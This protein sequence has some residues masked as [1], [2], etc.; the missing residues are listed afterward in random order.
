MAAVS[1]A[2]RDLT[3][4]RKFA[5][6]ARKYSEEIQRLPQILEIKDAAGIIHTDPPDMARAMAA[7]FFPQPVAADTVGIA[8]TIYPRKPEGISN[9]INQA[10]VEEIP[11]SFQA[12]RPR[13][14]GC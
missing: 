13:C 3:K 1:E 7:H 4:V 10:E 2:S 14:N 12:T 8:G 11:E 9:I 5:K 6:L